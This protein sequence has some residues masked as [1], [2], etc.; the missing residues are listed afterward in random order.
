[1]RFI[2]FTPT[3]RGSSAGVRFLYALQKHLILAGEECITMDFKAPFLI[4]QDDI[5][6]YPEII[7]DNPLKANKVVRWVLAPPPPNRWKSSDLII[8]FHP[9]YISEYDLHIQFDTIE[10]F[11]KD[12]KI[13]RTLDCFYVGKGSYTNYPELDNALEITYQWPKFR[14]TL[15]HLFN[16]AETFYLFDEM[17]I[18]SFEAQRCGVPNIKLVNDEGIVDYPDF[19]RGHNTAPIKEQVQSLIEA[20]K[21]L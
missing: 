18:I 12:K 16:K 6:I 21:C 15:A 1:M 8:A 13:E 4:E 20:C 7:V 11:F 17:S 19:N 3:Y 2:I 10:P 9:E 5:V 14:R